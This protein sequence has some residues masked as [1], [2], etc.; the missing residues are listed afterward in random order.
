MPYLTDILLEFDCMYFII[1]PKPKILKTSV[2][3]QLFMPI[4]YINYILF[5]CVILLHRLD[6]YQRNLS[7]L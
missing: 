4:K 7:Q 2:Y 1:P 6:L 5:L 3:M